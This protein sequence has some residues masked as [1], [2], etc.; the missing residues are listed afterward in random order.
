MKMYVR[1][2]LRNLRRNRLFSVINIVGLSLS[3]SVGLV[4]ILNIKKQFDFDNYHPYPDRTYRIVTDKIFENGIDNYAT[5][6]GALANELASYSFVENVSTLRQGESVS[7]S[8]GGKELP[9]SLRYA[10]SSFLNIFDFELLL[11]R[12]HFTEKTLCGILN[13]L[14][15][16]I[17]P[18]PF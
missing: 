13:V 3:M 6:P 7:V 5:S 18:Y 10:D 12:R 1:I 11:T 14:M 17:F 4:F 9:V 15:H 2:A 8:S 16:E